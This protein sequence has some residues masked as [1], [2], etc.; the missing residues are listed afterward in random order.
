MKSFA[1]ALAA[2]VS[3]ASLSAFA[4]RDGSDIL[5]QQQQIKRLQAERAKANAP[6]PNEQQMLEDCRK[7]MAPK[8]S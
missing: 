4:G 6:T 2:V 8:Q 1:I 3:L 5:V 7:M